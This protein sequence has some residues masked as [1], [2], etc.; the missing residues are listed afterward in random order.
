MKQGLHYKK[1][2]QMLF[3]VIVV[4]QL[5]VEIS[6]FIVCQLKKNLK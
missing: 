3:L 4:W 2:L 1:S 6:Y 5:N